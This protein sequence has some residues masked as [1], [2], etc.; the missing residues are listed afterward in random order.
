VH[1]H[2]VAMK[3]RFLMAIPVGWCKK[4]EIWQANRWS[5][6]QVSLLPSFYLEGIVSGKKYS[7]PKER[8]KTISS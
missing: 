2:L 4:V 7:S 3:K 6:V 8:N 5:S 1:G